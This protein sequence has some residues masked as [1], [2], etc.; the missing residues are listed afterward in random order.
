MLERG[1]ILIRQQRHY[2]PAPLRRKDPGQ[3]VEFILALQLP[4]L[5][6]VL[7]NAPPRA[8]PA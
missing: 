3:C 4:D 8:C 6:N 1:D 2:G 5:F 7:F